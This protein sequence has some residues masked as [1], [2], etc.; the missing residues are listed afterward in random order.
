M[1]LPDLSDKI[2]LFWERRSFRT[3][4]IIVI[5]IGFILYIL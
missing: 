3:K 5:T 1:T 4:A 2:A